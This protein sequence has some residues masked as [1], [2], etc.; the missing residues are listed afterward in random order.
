MGFEGVVP[1][2]HDFC[3]FFLLLPD[4]SFFLLMTWYRFFLFARREGLDY[5]CFF[6][7]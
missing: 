3:F 4:D 1:L 6:L 2:E 7:F 5:A